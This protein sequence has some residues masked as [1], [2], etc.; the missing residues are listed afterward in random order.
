[1][2]LSGEQE[3]E[4]LVL[5]MKAQPKILRR[6]VS[7]IFHRLV[8][9]T[10]RDT[11]RLL[12]GTIKTRQLRQMGHPY[13]AALW[14]KRDSAK[15]RKQAVTRAIKRILGKGGKANLLPINK[16]TGRLV[17]SQYLMQSRDKEGE[18]YEYGFKIDYAQWVLARQGTTKMRRRGFWREVGL[19]Y[20][21]YARHA[22]FSSLR[23]GGRGRLNG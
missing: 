4:K 15:P 10:V 13:A 12:H 9:E 20:F 7:E 3:L 5:F 23:S 14:L 22:S 21:H 18:H 11:Q 1:M 19:R 2:R 6:D 16:Q 17:A 8:N